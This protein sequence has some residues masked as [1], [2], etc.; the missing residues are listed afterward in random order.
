MTMRW[1]LLLVLVALVGCEMRG[2]TRSQLFGKEPPDAASEPPDG[3][4]EP[5][6]GLVIDVR[7]L[8]PPDAALP[9]GASPDVTVAPPE[10]IIVT[11]FVDGVCDNLGTMVGGAGAHTC[12]YDGKASYRLRIRGIPPGTRVEIGARKSGYLPYPDTAI[13][14]L[15]AKGNTHDFHLR[16]A[17]GSCDNPPDAAPCVCNRDAGCEPS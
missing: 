6:D 2:L 3:A 15:D 14:I 7:P 13:I 1:S 9:D 10:G 17:S 12:S 5:P 8:D 11:G 4:S 16:P